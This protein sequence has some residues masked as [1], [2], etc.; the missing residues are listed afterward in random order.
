MDKRLHNLEYNGVEMTFSDEKRNRLDISPVAQTS[1]SGPTL[2]RVMLK[3]DS[4]IVTAHVK[5]DSEH[6]ATLVV[7]GTAPLYD[8]EPGGEQEVPL[9]QQKHNDSINAMLVTTKATHLQFTFVKK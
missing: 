5:N 1:L 9:G 6:T 7:S 3:S 2:Y 8:A 4:S